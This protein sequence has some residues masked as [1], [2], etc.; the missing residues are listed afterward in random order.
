MFIK[1]LGLGSRFVRFAQ[2]AP[3]WKNVRKNFLAQNKKCSACGSSNDL[4]V[5]HIIPVHINPHLEL[6]TSNLIVLCSKSCHLLIGHLMDWKSWNI[7]VIND[8]KNL[9]SKISDRPYKQ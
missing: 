1:I 9:S 5:H 4:E 6:D 2:R 7:D 8:C 3:Q